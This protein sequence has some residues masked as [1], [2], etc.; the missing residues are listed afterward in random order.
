V[1]VRTRHVSIEA[2]LEHATEGL[3]AAIRTW[4]SEQWW[5]AGDGE[6]G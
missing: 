6:F 1:V 3:D 2:T 4:L 5:A